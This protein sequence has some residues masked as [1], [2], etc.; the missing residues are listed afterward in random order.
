MFQQLKLSLLYEQ[1]SGNVFLGRDYTSTQRNFSQEVALQIDKEIRH[2]VD[3]CHTQAREVIEAHR[4]DLILIA[5]T[6]LERESI[7]SEQIEYLLKYRTLDAF[8]AEPQLNSEIL[9]DVKVD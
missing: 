5:E 4:E 9:E 2:I 7:T 1:V 8:P 3:T 6:L